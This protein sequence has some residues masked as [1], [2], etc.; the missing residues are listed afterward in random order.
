MDPLAF[1]ASLVDSL[2]W[3]AAVVLLAF[4]FRHS[5]TQLIPY[6]RRLKYKDIELEFDRQLGEVREELGP[7][8]ALPTALPS[9]ESPVRYFRSLAEISPR[10][11]ILEAWLEFE[12]TANQAVETLGVTAKGR[13][14]SMQGLFKALSAHE[15]ISHAEVDALTRL[16]A[17]RNQVVH[18]PEPEISPE[19]IGEYA[20]MVQ[21]IASGIEQ[22][23]DERG[24]S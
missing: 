19:L 12:L 16:R 9:G 5:L 10:A 3:P 13:P 22:R 14:L 15:L 18:G 17:L 1:V 11:A 7:A 24:A 6:L 20:V 2:A 21:R 8:E 23:L 4:V